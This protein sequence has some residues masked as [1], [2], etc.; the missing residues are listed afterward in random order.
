MGPPASF[1]AATDVG[2]IREGNED[3]WTA[4]PER[5]LFAVA[6]G[7][8]GHAA[9]EI[10]SRLAVRALE[11]GVAG[12]GALPGSVGDARRLLAGAVRAAGR[13]IRGEAREHPGRRGMG[14]TLTSLLL[15]PE[16]DGVLAHVGD[17]RAY[18][19]R[20]GRLERL[21]RD[22]TW[23]QEQVDRGALSEDEARRH[24]ASSVLTRALGTDA[25]AEPDVAEVEWKPGDLYLLCSDGLTAALPEPELA[26]ALEETLAEA[27]DLEAVAGALV[28]EANRRGG[29]DNI[30]VVLVRT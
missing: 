15:L 2:R 27:Q 5:G 19:L 26:G 22:H 6:D 3:A 16:G 28:R 1:A 9:G 12:D 25:G 10:A 30:T 21:T 13:R 17:S 23:V 20:G 7:M 11:E 8:G 18:R 24:P 29:P 4:V 14:T